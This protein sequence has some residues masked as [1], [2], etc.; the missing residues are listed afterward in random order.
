MLVL[1]TE[2]LKMRIGSVK[3]LSFKIAHKTST[4]RVSKIIKTITICFLKT[5]MLI[6]L[7]TKL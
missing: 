3:Y 2:L 1:G 5:V 4:K 6:V 7:Q